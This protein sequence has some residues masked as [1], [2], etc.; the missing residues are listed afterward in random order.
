MEESD[1]GCSSGV[2]TWTHIVCDLHKWPSWN[3]V[4]LG[5]LGHF[6]KKTHVGQSWKKA[7]IHK[8]IANVAS[9][10]GKILEKKTAE[11]NILG[12]RGGSC[13][14]KNLSPNLPNEIG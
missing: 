7:K 8:N 14:K 4:K 9:G 10:L 12:G 6:F 3:R 13:R 5:K 2:R 1:I 11:K